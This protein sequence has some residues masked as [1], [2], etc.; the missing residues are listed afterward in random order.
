MVADSSFGVLPDLQDEDYLYMIMDYLPGGDMMTWLIKKEIFS[1]EETKFYTAELV[2]ALDSIHS[3]NYVHRLVYPCLFS[4]FVVSMFVRLFS[5]PRVFCTAVLC[6]SHV[7]VHVMSALLIE[8][9]YLMT[10]CVWSY[11]SPLR[12]TCISCLSP[13][14]C[15]CVLC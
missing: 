3:M 13:F 8:W 7:C 9:I 11:L 2:L 14:P 6:C 10:V 15:S 12:C 5:C 1:L 4:L